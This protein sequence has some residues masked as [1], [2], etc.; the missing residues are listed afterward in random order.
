MTYLVSYSLHAVR[1]PRWM[2][3]FQKRGSFV[4]DADTCEAAATRARAVLE[5]AVAY[6]VANLAMPEHTRIHIASVLPTEPPKPTVE[7]Y[8]AATGRTTK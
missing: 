1:E 6:G 7:E 5:D 3:P 8:I 4:V 2:A